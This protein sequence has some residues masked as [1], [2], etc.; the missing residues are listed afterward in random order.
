MYTNQELGIIGRAKVH[1]FAAYLQ[2]EWLNKGVLDKTLDSEQLPTKDFLEKRY[3]GILWN[4][5]RNM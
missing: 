4:I 5:L 1:G 2:C 3:D